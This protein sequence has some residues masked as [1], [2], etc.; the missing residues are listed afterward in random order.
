MLAIRVDS[1][2]GGVAYKK[3]FLG[4]KNIMIFYFEG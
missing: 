1:K 4:L 3:K 2:V